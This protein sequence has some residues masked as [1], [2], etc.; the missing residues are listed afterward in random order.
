LNPVSLGIEP[1]PAKT[2]H[3]ARGPNALR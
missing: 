1:C 3:P 2:F